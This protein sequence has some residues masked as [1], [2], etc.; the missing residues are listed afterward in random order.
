MCLLYFVGLLCDVVLCCDVCFCLIWFDVFSWLLGL[1]A[2]VL[3]GG[4]CLFGVVFFS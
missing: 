4:V 1:F 2:F 3:E